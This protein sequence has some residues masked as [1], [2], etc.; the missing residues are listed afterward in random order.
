[1]DRFEAEADLNAALAS[2]GVVIPDSATSHEALAIAESAI[3]DWAHANG[4]DDPNRVVAE[5]TSVLGLA[6]YFARRCWRK[7]DRAALIAWMRRVVTQALACDAFALC[8]V[9]DSVFVRLSVDLQGRFCVNSDPL[10]GDRSIASI[11]IAEDGSFDPAELLDS[12]EYLAC[13]VAQ[14]PTAIVCSEFR[15]DA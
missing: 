6:G 4:S 3:F 9:D 7:I 11:A 14:P 13:D 10:D 2:A 5:L 8:T 15:A 1:M 12:C